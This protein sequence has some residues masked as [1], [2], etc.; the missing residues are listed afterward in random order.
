MLSGALARAHPYPSIPTELSTHT[1]AH[2]NGSAY[3]NAHLT[4]D[5]PFICDLSSITSINQSMERCVRT[6][7]NEEIDRHGILEDAK[8]AMG[9][10]G[11]QWP[12]H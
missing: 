11:P 2:A 12:R 6:R 1:H 10:T 5:Q 9:I 8:F 3:T 7:L 4:I